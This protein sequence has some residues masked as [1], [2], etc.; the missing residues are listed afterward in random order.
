M[1]EIISSFRKVLVHNIAP[2]DNRTAR[3]AVSSYSI[4]G[5]PPNIAEMQEEV[6]SSFDKMID[7]KLKL[8]SIHNKI[9]QAGQ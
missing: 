1:A 2:E 6:Q 8:V 9:K 4:V 7:I 3:S 5:M